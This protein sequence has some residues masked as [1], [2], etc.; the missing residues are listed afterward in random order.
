MKQKY[1][2]H[3]VS[4]THWDREWYRPFQ[5]FRMR[6]VDLTD[7]LL[8]LLEN[9][10]EY[11][12]FT[13][14]GQTIVVDDYLKIRPEN[15]DR[16]KKLIEENKILIGPWYN[17]PDEFLISG[18]GM[19]RNL[20]LGYKMGQEWG[21][22]MR[23]GYVPDAFGHI[24]QL[25][26]LMQGFGI[27]SVVLFRGITTDQVDSEFTWKGADGT[28]VLCIKMP[29]NNAYS[30]FFYCM[31]GTLSAPQDEFDVELSRQ[32]MSKLI[33]D[34]ENERPTT[35]NLLFMDGVDHIYANP[36]TVKIMRDVNEN[37]DVGTIK[38]SS[39]QEFIDAVRADNPKLK[40]YEGELRWN[41]RAWKLSGI[42][43]NVM[44]SR[45]HLKQANHYLENLMEKWVE[46]FATVAWLE[47]KEYPK[48]YIDLAWRY[49]LKNQ[50]HDSICGCSVDQVHKDMVYRYDQA[51]LIAEP[52]LD[53]TLKYIADKTNTASPVEKLAKKTDKTS[54]IS[55]AS[56][57]PWEAAQSGSASSPTRIMPITVFNPLSW[58]RSE[59]VDT[60]VAIPHDWH[61]NGM[62]ITDENGN[63]VTSKIFGPLPN[64]D[65]YQAPYDIPV[66]LTTTRFNVSFYAEDVPSL[67]YK[68][69]YLHGLSTPWRASG[70][71]ISS[72]NIAQ[73]EHLVLIVESDGTLTIIDKETERQYI[74]CMIFEDGGDFGEGWHYIKP[75]KDLIATSLGA[76]VTVSIAEDTDLRATFKI[77]TLMD[78]PASRHANGQERSEEKT[79]LKITSYVSL[80][81][82]AKRVDVVTEVDNTAKDHRLRV[83]FPSGIETDYANAETAWDVVSRT[84]HT[85]ECR[86]WITPMPPAH[87]QRSFVDLNDG[88]AGLTIINDGLIEY[89]AKG[90]D[91]RTIALTLMRCFGNG[92]GGAHQQVQGQ[93]LG[94]RTFRFAIMP[95]AGTWD[96][97]KVWQE[98]WGHNLPMKAVQ[99][100]IHEG[101]LKTT[102][103]YL[104]ISDDNIVISA[105]K[106]ADA[107]DKI[108]TRV[109]N[110]T[111]SMA[112]Q[113][114]I[115]MPK[116]TENAMFANLNEEIEDKP[117]I[118]KSSVKIDIPA[119]RIITI[120]SDVKKG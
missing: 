87:P 47:G 63:E 2:M 53:N 68:T 32:E 17:Q 31:R 8:D 118:G 36:K 28:E 41:N 116:N 95:H 34:C 115:D 67:G 59:V 108:I 42:L 88:E 19:I 72:V 74:D 112:G 77:D 33:S 39:L 109:F 73:N 102:G 117:S 60:E 38:Y 4:H 119:K 89:E 111:Q 114:K 50:P 54:K 66:G 9:D 7:K 70:S 99:T 65:M 71:L 15:K 86:D 25:P 90:D 23:V 97:A 20:M 14:D 49:M 94:M 56:P 81:K 22:W 11:K 64:W 85:P 6:L 40:T 91:D 79:Q 1:T 45:V 105:L 82:G 113:V 24:S 98:A 3:V 96:S 44:S 27:D 26:Q 110:F 29:D 13:F 48:S 62:K 46:P 93:L 76:A 103:S 55:N 107:D 35:S 43:A 61:Q 106:K 80:A 78:V 75:P 100:D 12:V 84:V 52:I 18:E 83:L 16:L 37:M 101:E 92:L 58:D 104:K 51:K 120:A 69:Y 21:N 5:H 57:L 30:N 10:P